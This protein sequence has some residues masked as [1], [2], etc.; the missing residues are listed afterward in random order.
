MLSKELEDL[1]NK[2]NSTIFYVELGKPLENE[3]W[4]CLGTYIY[5]AVSP[6]TIVYLSNEIETG[7]YLLVFDKT[8]DK[9]QCTNVDTGELKICSYDEDTQTISEVTQ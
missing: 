4:Y 1:Y 3:V 2:T 7:M 8:S 9:Y 5:M 6:P